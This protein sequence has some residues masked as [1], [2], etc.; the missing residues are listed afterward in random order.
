MNGLQKNLF[1]LLASIVRNDSVGNVRTEDSVSVLN[2]AYQYK[3]ITAIYNYIADDRAKAFFTQS[4]IKSNIINANQQAEMKRIFDYAEENNIFLLML[5]GFCIGKYYPS[6]GFKEMSD[7]DLFYKIQQKESVDKMMRELGYT[8]SERKE[9]H[10]TWAIKER[11]VFVELHFSIAD[12]SEDF[13]SQIL[14]RKKNFENCSN[15]FIMS[16][17]DL[18]VY[19]LIHFC[20]H[21]R[22]GTFN[23]RQLFDI[24]VIKEKVPLDFERIDEIA[25][26]ENIKLFG[27]NILKAFDS[28]FNG[29]YH[30]ETA[31]FAEYLSGNISFGNN[32]IAKLA[33]DSN[34]K[35]GFAMKRLFPR[36]EKILIEYPDYNDKKL[37]L[38]VG[39]V[40]RFVHIMKD[41]REEAFYQYRIM[42]KIDSKMIAGGKEQK[43]FLK[44][45]G[46]NNI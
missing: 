15:V 31:E 5:K 43:E 21:L 39:Y 44:K 20:H 32:A 30:E 22:N 16:N 8:F 29:V 36:K 3:V 13:L 41:K 4:L 11:N 9:N 17:E 26:R 33:Y 40:K 10:E 2:L 42:K 7:I 34:G 27:D 28:I 38:P 12:V 19:L 46:I 45:Y 37:L 18:Y 14:E 35:I 23:F 25:V 6:K 24:F 1:E